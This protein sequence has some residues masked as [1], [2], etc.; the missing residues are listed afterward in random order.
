MQVD[1]QR[2]HLKRVREDDPYG[3][4]PVK[5][6]RLMEVESYGIPGLPIELQREIIMCLSLRMVYLKIPLVSKGWKK[7][8]DDLFNTVGKFKDYK[9]LTMATAFRKVTWAKEDLK[10]IANLFQ[11]EYAII[12]A[13][14]KAEAA[15]ICVVPASIIAAAIA[16]LV[17]PHFTRSVT[18]G[19]KGVILCGMFPFL[20]TKDA[21]DT[22]FATIS[23][24]RIAVERYH[25]ARRRLE[26]W[27]RG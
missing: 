11:N 7:I 2:N 25:A 21:V 5:R 16:L 19:I 13:I 6:Q 12:R 27:S 9:F 3:L 8:S 24:R 1:P 22:L 20:I 23:T 4:V 10:S 18:V 15:V 17:A 26:R 14:L